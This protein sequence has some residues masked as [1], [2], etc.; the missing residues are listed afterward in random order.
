MKINFN[1]NTTEDI[2]ILTE[3]YICE[4]YK[5]N[6][7]RKL[8][9]DEN[10]DIK[11]DI[12]DSLNKINLDIVVHTGFKNESHDFIDKCNHHVS[13]KSCIK[14][15]KICP[16][17][18]G[19]TTLKYYN[20]ATNNEFKHF[21]YLNFNTL[22]NNYLENT[23]ICK[24]TLFYNFKQGKMYYIT[25]NQDNIQF[26]TNL[27]YMTTQTIESWKNSNTIKVFLN[28]KWES[29]ADIQIHS[30][31]NSI[32]YR[33]HFNKLL[34]LIQSQNISGINVEQF[35]LQ[36]EYNINLIKPS[37]E[38][39]LHPSIAYI[40]CKTKL[41]NLIGEN[42]ETYTNK[43]LSEFNSFFDCFSG[44]GI[45]SYYMLKKQVKNVISNDIQYYSVILNTFIDK[46]IDISKIEDIIFKLNN[47]NNFVVTEFDYIYHNYSITRTYFTQEN[48]LK[49][50]KIRQNIELLLTNKIVNFDEYKLLIKLLL[51]AVN[52]VSNVASV[53][54]AYL[55]Q[56]KTNALK[57]LELDNKLLNYIIKD[58]NKDLS[59]YVYN[60]NIFDILNNI[61]TDIAYIDTPYN[62]RNYDSNYHLLETIC[63]YDNP[64]IEGKT[65]LRKE[66][67]KNT[68]LF[69][70]T[71]SVKESFELLIKNINSKYIFIS[72]NNES[73][74]TK[75][76]IIELLNKYTSNIKVVE[77][78][79]KKFTTTN[80]NSNVIE[81]L[82][83][84]TKF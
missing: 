69:C 5:I 48:A 44:T 23:F 33:F 2:G 24:C 77:I 60:N 59:H 71:N 70:S 47:I 68:K 30:N 42:I 35:D 49:I 64:I 9:C 54:G 62:Q 18:I 74:L 75:E 28:N 40:G 58:K 13:V 29:I 39:K 67:N 84:A 3:K 31:R 50:D 36:N 41:A 10:N 80:K 19:Q 43:K 27:K 45:M 66:K 8:C 17:N 57:T 83:C 32:T 22:L 51:F 65:G 12:F 46:N 53:Y 26:N 81:Y 37:N 25:K 4:Y 11:N 34:L 72:Y 15:D 6:F 16:Q 82:F 1:I 56:Y 73:L 55:K 38:C 21:F 52:K 61:K 79:Y 78:P 14:N 63:R 7:D 76:N 20:C